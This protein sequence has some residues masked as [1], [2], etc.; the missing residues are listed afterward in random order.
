MV[1]KIV[2]Q[3]ITISEH[4]YKYY[5]N[6]RDFIQKYVFPGG[7]LPTKSA[8]AILAK[9]NNLTFK[10]HISF[11]KDYAKTLS[12]WRKNFQ[13]NW[14]NIEKLGFNQNFKRLW[15]YYLTYCEVGFNSGSINVSQFLLEKKNFNYEEI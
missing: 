5:S 13:L 12:I 10:E 7:M 3:I 14:N 11:G 2:L 1:K 4:N 8:L 15:E 6:S 9:H